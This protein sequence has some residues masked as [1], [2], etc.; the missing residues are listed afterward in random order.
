MTDAMNIDSEQIAGASKSTPGL[1][2]RA[3]LLKRL[4]SD[5]AQNDRQRFFLKSKLGASTCTIWPS[6]LKKKLRPASDTP[7]VRK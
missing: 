3:K 5:A 1:K 7:H 4:K 2:T 6:V